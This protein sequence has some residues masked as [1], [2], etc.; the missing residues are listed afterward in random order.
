MD[1]LLAHLCVCV[2]ALCH[3]KKENQLNVL[4]VFLFLFF[5][6]LLSIRILKQMRLEIYQFFLFISFFVCL[7]PASLILVLVIYGQ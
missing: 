4:R 6:V 7:P 2:C 3:H 5:I 1:Q